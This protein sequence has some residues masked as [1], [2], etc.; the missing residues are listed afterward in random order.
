MTSESEDST[1]NDKMRIS[2]SNRT[3]ELW[4]VSSSHR[5]YT[6]NA[7]RLTRNS[8]TNEYDNGVY[9]FRFT[10]G[11]RDT[12]LDG[13]WQGKGV[14]MNIESGEKVNFDWEMINDSGE[15][16]HPKIFT[17]PS[18]DVTKEEAANTKYNAKRKKRHPNA[19]GLELLDQGDVAFADGDYKSARD[20]YK[21]AEDHYDNEEN[22]TNKEDDNSFGLNTL[23]ILLIIPIGFWILGRY[24]RQSIPKLDA[25]PNPSANPAANPAA[26]P[27][28]GTNVGVANRS[29]T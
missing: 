17:P 26:N 2:F 1:S 9:Y 12:N 28:H 16:N 29:N 20:F 22:Q 15:H 14:K 18:S 25:N 24:F 10:E 8:D 13:T 6:D 4:T 7:E 23:L 3:P 11:S 21:K 27:P 19:R 5:V